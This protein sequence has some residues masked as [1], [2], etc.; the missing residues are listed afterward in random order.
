MV[1]TLQHKTETEPYLLLVEDSDD[2][3]YFFERALRK[4]GNSC[5]MRRVGNGAEAI[6]FIQKASI[7]DR[8]V[9]PSITFLDL[10]MPVV[11]GFE[12]LDWLQAQP[13]S[14]QLRVI[15]L[16]GS[17]HLDDKARAA[18]LGAADYLVKPVRASDLN[19]FL[20]DICPVIPEKGVGF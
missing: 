10:K 16:S 2:D 6:E 17:E 20:E 8:Q 4:S 9:L 15:V 7:S 1:H 11:N 5:P 3:A 13:F 19:R 18:R 14:H 12:V